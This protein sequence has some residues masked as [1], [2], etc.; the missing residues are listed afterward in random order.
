VILGDRSHTFLYEAGGVAALGGIHPHTV[1]NRPDGTIALEDIESAVRTPNVHFPTSR[2]ICLENTH[3]RCNGSP[4]TPD[5]T[6][7]VAELAET[8]H[9]KV[10]LDGARVFN[11][12]QALGVDVRELTRGAHSVTFCLSKGLSCPVGSVICGPWDFIEDARHVRKML[13]GGMR[14][15]GVIAAA[16]IEA[17]DGMVERLAEDHANARRLAEGIADIP[18]LAIDPDAFRTNI[19]YFAFE[20]GSGRGDLVDRMAERGVRFLQTGIDSFRMVTH[21]GISSGD[22]DAAVRAL[23]DVMTQSR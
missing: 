2:L 10:H 12:A 23:G 21:H 11:A 17:L 13:G 18:G 7:R 9:M 1:P 20:N 14:Q 16:G 8:H 19:I 15:C 6:N 4:L 22:V 5:Y 3:N